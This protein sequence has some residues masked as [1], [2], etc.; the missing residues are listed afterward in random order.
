MGFK[1]KS[2]SSNIKIEE[3]NDNYQRVY[4]V[5]AIFGNITTKHIKEILDNW[6]NKANEIVMINA[7][8]KRENRWKEWTDEDMNNYYEK[9][10]K[11]SISERTIERCIKD[12][13]QELLKMAG[14]IV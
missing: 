3:K 4:D 12:K 5:I 11:H 13:I 2:R 8:M 6:T 9:N 7:K 10:K 1:R 14:I